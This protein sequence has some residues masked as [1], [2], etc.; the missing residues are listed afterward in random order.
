SKSIKPN[1]KKIKEVYADKER[2]I[3]HSNFLGKWKLHSISLDIVN[4]E[5]N[6]CRIILTDNKIIKKRFEKDKDIL[7][8][9]LT[10]MI[11]NSSLIPQV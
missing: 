1:L 10:D 6:N 4:K 8:I 2:I 3:S 11:A 7:V 9:Y 5:E